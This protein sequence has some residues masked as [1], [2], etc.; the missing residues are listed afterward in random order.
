MRRDNAGDWVSGIE[1]HRQRYRFRVAVGGEIKSH[2][3]PTQAEAERHRTAAVRAQEQVQAE[4]RVLTWTEAIEEYMVHQAER[5]KASEASR[6]VVKDR[7]RRFFRPVLEGAVQLT[8]DGGIALYRE[9]RTRPGARGAPPSVQEQHHCLSRAKA[10]VRWLVKQKKLRA[11]VLADLEALGVPKAGE[12]SKPQL[13]RDGLWRLW[14]VALREA[15]KGDAGAAAVLCCSL[16]GMRAS[17]VANRTREHLDAHGTILKSTA[18]GQ[19]VELSLMGETP[20]AEGIM[21][22]LRHA[23]ALQA[24]GKLPQAPLI[25]SGH[26]RWW[27]RREVQR[28]CTL[29]GVRVVPPHGLRG[30]HASVGRSLGISPGLLA[31][32][33]AHSQRVQERHYATPEAVASGQVARVVGVLGK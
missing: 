18:K 30:T 19:T 24:R 12:A 7:L 17:T 10:L 15:G 22:Q 23:L 5:G 8:E 28:L 2:S 13:N 32:S 6:K 29:A 21:A 31:G 16:L 4:R 20:D 25:G 1:R 26:D 3:Y 33:L 27:V 14:E 11:D 9:L